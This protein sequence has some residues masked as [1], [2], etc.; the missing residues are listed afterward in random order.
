MEYYI[1]LCDAESS[2]I[3]DITYYLE[4][5]ELLI[6]FKKYYIDEICYV[7]VSYKTFIAFSECSSFGKFYLQYIKTTF[8]TKKTKIMADKIIK[9]KI[10]VKNINKDW[11]YVGEKGVYLDA[12]LLYNEEKDQYEN[13]GMIVQDVPSAI[14]KADPTKKGQIL[15]NC[16]LFGGIGAS[17]SNAS[18]KS[19][20]KTEG[21]D[22]DLPF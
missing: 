14:Y 21:L 2:L 15:G 9:L 4:D 8:K 7:G 17:S 19:K 16:K 3:K 20:A 22:D 5:E 11:L 1:E 18:E 13:N 12:T 10:N 6:R